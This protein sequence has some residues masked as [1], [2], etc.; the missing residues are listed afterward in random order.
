MLLEV[1]ALWVRMNKYN[2]S[3]FSK[4][5]KKKVKKNS[6]LL[7]FLFLSLLWKSKQTF[8]E[9]QSY[10]LSEPQVALALMDCL[11]LGKSSSG[12][13]LEG[14]ECSAQCA[15]LPEQHLKSCSPAWVMGAL[16]G[17]WKLIVHH[18]LNPAFSSLSLICAQSLSGAI[19]YFLWVLVAL[20]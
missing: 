10:F 16:L 15:L 5:K 12:R 2:Q 13:V 4:Q 18:G 6:Q 3:T 8:Q 7:S 17:S 19:F 20:D 1:R 11:S 14:W 9:Q